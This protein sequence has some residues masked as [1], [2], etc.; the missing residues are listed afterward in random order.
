MYDQR[1]LSFV[2]ENKA[3]LLL[4]TSMKIYVN[5]M[6]SWLAGRVKFITID[7]FVLISNIN[8]RCELC[9]ACSNKESSHKFLYNVFE[10][11]SEELYGNS[12]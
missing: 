10:W 6:A 12:I 5:G 8:S 4:V 2:I 1:A 9:C 11:A 3:I 7:L